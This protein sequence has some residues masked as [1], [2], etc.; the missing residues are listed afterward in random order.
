MRKFDII[1]NY[2]KFVPDF[3]IYKYCPSYFG[4]DD[5]NC[6]K[7]T[8]REEICKTCWEQESEVNNEIILS[9]LWKLYNVNKNEIK[10]LYDKE[11]E[12]LKEIQELCPHKNIYIYNDNE[13][14]PW[15]DKDEEEKIIKKCKDCGKILN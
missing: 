12:I 1:T 4:L 13:Y 2:L 6:S 14:A 5:I 11:K 3:D 15:F 7:Y 10:V 8:N 9:A